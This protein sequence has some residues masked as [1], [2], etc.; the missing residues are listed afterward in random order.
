VLDYIPTDT[1]IL[2]IV[3]EHNE[4]ALLEYK[5]D[6]TAVVCCLLESWKMERDGLLVSKM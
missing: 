3:Y 6:K 5:D 2:V 1:F 4:N